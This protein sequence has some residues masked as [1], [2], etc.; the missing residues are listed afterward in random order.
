MVEFQELSLRMERLTDES[1][2]KKHVLEHETTETLTAQIEL[3][4]TA[5]DFRKAHQERQNL[6]EQWEHT[7]EQM[8][9][10]DKEMDLLAAVSLFLIYLIYNMLDTC[11]CLRTKFYM[12]ILHLLLILC[13]EISTSE[14]RS[15][16]ERRKY[17][18]ETAVLRQ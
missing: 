4:K 1:K 15:K 13:S 2:Q 10:R 14:S 12:F 18:R 7:I 9:R 8:Q 5:E 3:D 11:K 16:K 17:K 6:I